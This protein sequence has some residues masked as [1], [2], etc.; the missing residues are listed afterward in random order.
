VINVARATA[1]AETSV[2]DILFSF[3]KTKMKNEEKTKDT[4][5]SWNMAPRIY[6]QHQGLYLSISSV[7]L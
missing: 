1:D 3:L 2:V 6:R 7:P 5:V 4:T